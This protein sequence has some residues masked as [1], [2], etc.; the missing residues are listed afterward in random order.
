[1]QEARRT[2]RLMRR[3]KLLRAA[4]LG[5]MRLRGGGLGDDRVLRPRAPMGAA[6]VE[7]QVVRVDGNKVAIRWHSVSNQVVLSSNHVEIS[8]GGG[9]G[10]SHS[11]QA[12]FRYTG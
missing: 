12:A 6:Y 2:V 11:K 7:S 3:E 1:M 8:G 9:E 4:R 5:P 10:G